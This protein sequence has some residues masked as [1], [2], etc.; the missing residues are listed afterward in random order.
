MATQILMDGTPTDGA[1]A[2]IDALV[3][4]GRWIDGDGGTTTIRYNFA[5]GFDSRYGTTG[6]AWLAHEQTA[7]RS[8][9][10]AWEAVA[11]VDFVESATTPDIKFWS[12]TDARMTA[13]TGLS[14]ILGFHE[15]PGYN[16]GQPL[17]GV[18]NNQGYGWNSSGLQKGAY[19][20]ITLIH[21]LGHGLGLAHPH[22]GGDEFDANLFPGVTA[23]FG[24]YGDFNLNQGIYTTMSYNDG[25]AAALPSPS[26]YYG[27][28]LTPMALDI[29]AIQAIYGAN[30]TAAG[31]NNTY[32]LPKA[33]VSGTGWSCIWDTGGIDTISAAGTTAACVINLNAATL[34]GANAGGIISRIS[35][36]YGGVTIANGVVIE[37]ATG[38]SGA[39]TI[40]GNV[41]ANVLNG[42]GG[43]DRMTGSNGNDIYYADNAGD[44]VTETNA[45]SATGGVDLVLSYLSAYTLGANVENG[46]IVSSGTANMTGNGLANI[47]H[48]GA[49]A[50]VINGGAGIDTVSYAYASAGVSV[51][52]SV[53]TAQAT[54]GSGSDRLSGF[55]NVTGSNFSDKI[56][57][58]TG[59]NALAGVAGNDLICGYAGDDWLNGGL[60][61]DTIYGGAGLDTFMFNTALGATNVDTIA[62]FATADDTIRLEN[63][64]IFTALVDGVLDVIAFVLGTEALDADDRII[65]DTTSGALSYDADGFGGAAAIRFATLTSTVGSLTAADFLVV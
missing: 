2:W 28:Q 51:N 18:F 12:V 43:A 10:A 17:Y 9:L 27:Y 41:F 53:T 19:G 60:G 36:V 63:T 55:E 8:A 56:Y 13:L 30:T 49:G 44:I 7:M 23:E 65:F 59:N 46:R 16:S 50:N 22:D 39:D 1:N 25:W 21:E 4:G 58:T 6:S 40:T 11:N 14:G 45:V 3:W 37:N 42:G 64:G 33:N 62:G 29:A 5:S 31:G 61:N 48:A 54:G 24:D 34:V 38:G 47:I 52:I 20:Y 32:L 35:G 15:V 57:G 26:I